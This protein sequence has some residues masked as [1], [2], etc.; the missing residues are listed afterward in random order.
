MA[1]ASA[2]GVDAENTYTILTNIQGYD[3]FSLGPH[4]T[5]EEI[6]RA[7]QTQVRYILNPVCESSYGSRLTVQYVCSDPCSRSFGTRRRT[8][9]ICKRS[10]FMI[11]CSPRTTSSSPLRR[12]R[13]MTWHC[14]QHELMN[15]TSPECQT[16]PATSRLISHHRLHPHRRRC[17]A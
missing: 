4:S 15:P 9:E 10:K 11:V 6:T 8:Q 12:A 17:V 13:N 14:L 5:V 2:G 3:S 7:F 16:R 1:T